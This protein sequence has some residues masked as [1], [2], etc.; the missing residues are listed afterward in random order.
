MWATRPIVTTFSPVPRRMDAHFRLA[1]TGRAA[2]G[3]AA[4]EAQRWSDMLI[5]RVCATMRLHGR[6]IHRILLAAR[7]VAAAKP[8]YEAPVATDYSIASPF[9]RFCVERRY[10][11]LR[12][13]FDALIKETRRAGQ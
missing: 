7:M 8:I 12:P 4:L 9:S 2:I 3:Q 5:A 10:E 13:A 11:Y 6:G 1:R